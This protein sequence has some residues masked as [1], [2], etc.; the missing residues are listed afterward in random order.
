MATVMATKQYGELAGFAIPL[1]ML[2]TFITQSLSVSL[3]PAIS[4]AA[5]HKHF[6]TIHEQFE[7]LAVP[8]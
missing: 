8:L 7:H 6:K 1:L 4:E 3:V 5:A 2:P